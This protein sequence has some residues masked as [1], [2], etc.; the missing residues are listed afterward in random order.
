MGRE[1]ALARPRYRPDDATARDRLADAFWRLLSDNPFAK[2]TVLALV[3]EAGLNKN[4]F[5]YHYT[6]IDDLARTIV[7]NTFHPEALQRLLAQLEA[8]GGA[9]PDSQLEQSFDRLCLIA[10][11]HSTPALQEM[12][13]DALRDSW[14][15]TLHIDPEL[16]PLDKRLALEFAV[17]GVTAIFAHRAKLRLHFTFVDAITTDLRRQVQQILASVQP[18]ADT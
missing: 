8:T 15:G 13:K 3:R 14:A 9:T 2:L 12:L 7:A 17:G 16:L 1:L 11:D 18:V 6:D 5:Y 4:T 10:S